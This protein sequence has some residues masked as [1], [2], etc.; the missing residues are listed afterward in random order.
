MLN[1]SRRLMKFWRRW[2]LRYER[3]EQ[4][5]HPN[6]PNTCGLKC[7]QK[8]GHRR[9]RHPKTSASRSQPTTNRPV[10]STDFLLRVIK[11]RDL[12]MSAKCQKA[13]TATS[14]E[15]APVLGKEAGA[16]LPLSPPVLGLRQGHPKRTSF[17]C[18]GGLYY[19]LEYSSR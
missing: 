11:G 8:K 19:L 12:L 6:I 4:N 5:R 17:L 14:R 15:G 3:R 10:C 7:Q 18:C 2:S 1:R 13:D 9:K 16:Q